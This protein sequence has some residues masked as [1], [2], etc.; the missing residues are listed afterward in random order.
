[1]K[2]KDIK[3]WSSEVEKPIIEEWKN[4]EKF[5]FDLKSKKKIYSIDTPPPYVNAPVHIGQ[6]ITYCYIYFF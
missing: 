3:N 1:M 6:A 2:L 4:S 5:K